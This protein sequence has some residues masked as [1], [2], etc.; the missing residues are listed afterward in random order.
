MLNFFKPYETKKGALIKVQPI[1]TFLHHLRCCSLGKNIKQN[2]LLQILGVRH[3][4]NK[5]IAKFTIIVNMSED[6]D[7]FVV[8]VDSH[9]YLVIPGVSKDD[10]LKSTFTI[11][12][13][14]VKVG[15][16]SMEGSLNWV[17]SDSALLPEEE[18]K[19]SSAIGMAIESKET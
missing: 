17:W 16:L 12:L 10:S 5:Q 18:N 11:M 13:D 4:E 6:V 2:L 19:I 7:V 3:Y 1:S 14:G 9:E 15:D 8:N